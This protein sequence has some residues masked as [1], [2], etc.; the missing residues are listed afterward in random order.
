VSFY[1]NSDTYHLW[2]I[3]G[4]FNL[5]EQAGDMAWLAKYWQQIELAIKAS[6]DKINAS[7]P[8]AGLMVVTATAD[9]A[10]CCQGG[11]N[12]AANA[13]LYHVLIG[14]AKMAASLKNSTQAAA[15]SSAA[16]ALRCVFFK[17][18]QIHKYMHINRH[19][20]THTCPV[21]MFIA[22]CRARSIAR[23]GADKDRFWSWFGV[24]C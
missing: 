15:Y 12:I 5:V 21:L 13:V 7:P 17:H 6:T 8:G 20:H 19:T 1:G 3:A 2:A 10:R 16:A 14:A 24:G 22:R 9:W 23:R 18:V 11:K 4:T